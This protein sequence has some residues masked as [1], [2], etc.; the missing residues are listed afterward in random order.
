MVCFNFFCYTIHLTKTKSFR[1]SFK[2]QLANTKAQVYDLRLIRMDRLIDSKKSYSK[3]ST[4]LK[5][6]DSR[7][8]EHAYGGQEEE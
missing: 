8:D 6:W 2:I 4:H 3:I 1:F 7:Q 5:L